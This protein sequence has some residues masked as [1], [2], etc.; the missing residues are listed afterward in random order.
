[1]Y[2]LGSSSDA[3][4]TT[5][6][7]T[8]VA[9]IVSAR[10]ARIMRTIGSVTSTNSRPRPACTGMSQGVSRRTVRICSINEPGSTP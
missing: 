2:G 9:A 1:M 6:S 5:A 8:L 3:Q 7:I 4:I 10:D